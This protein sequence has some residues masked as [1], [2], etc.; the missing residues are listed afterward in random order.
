MSDSPRAR[1]FPGASLLANVL[2]II[3]GVLVTLSFAP[4]ADL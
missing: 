4:S 1:S 3:A 2:A